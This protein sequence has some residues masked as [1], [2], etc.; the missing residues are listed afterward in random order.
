MKLTLGTFYPELETLDNEYKSVHLLPHT[1]SQFSQSAIFNLVKTGKWTSDF[2]T[3]VQNNVLQLI[4]NKLPKYIACWANSQL[5]GNLFLGFDDNRLVSGIP[6]LTD[7]PINQIR[8]TITKTI[9]DNI[10]TETNLTTLRNQIEIYVYPLL[11]DTNIITDK[12]DELY[13]KF[14]QETRDYY[15]K[16]ENF[17][18]NHD[19]FLLRHRQCTQPLDKILNNDIYRQDLKKFIIKYSQ[20]PRPQLL[21]LLNSPEYIYIPDDNI[22]HD[23]DNP[24]RIFYWVAHFRSYYKQKNA[25]TKP[26][27]PMSPSIYHP[28][29]I[30]ANLPLMK[31]KFVQSNPN[32]KYYIIKIMCQVGHLKKPVYFR[33]LNN[34]KMLYRQRIFS[35]GPGCI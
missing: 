4:Y 23:R 20:T 12:T 19:L 3:L 22:L 25:K 31:A 14:S 16:L 26:E 35:N 5:D 17:N 34:N 32:L 9:H 1:L 24:D 28:K 6:I 30:L 29:Q 21:T 13:S 10:Q 11:I 33:N 2:N 7:I 15:L 27:R 8:D 18:I